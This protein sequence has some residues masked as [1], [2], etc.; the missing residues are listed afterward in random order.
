MKKS[1][2]LLNTK[3]IYIL[4]AI[5]TIVSAFI[6]YN[7]IKNRI[8]I[9]FIIGYIFFVALFLLYNVF[10]TILKVKQLKYKEIK[11]RL[12]MFVMSFILFSVS[13]YIFD[14]LFKPAKI[15]LDRNISIAFG[16][17][18]GISF[19]DLLLSKK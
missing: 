6:I 14:Y 13:A 11:V 1:V 9:G 7:D 15:N 19:F 18:F 3:I 4:F 12:F 2:S 8:A 17:A 16:V 5:A 10:I